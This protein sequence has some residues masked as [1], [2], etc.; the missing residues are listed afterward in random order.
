MV[1]Y[2]GGVAEAVAVEAALVLILGAGVR[3]PGEAC[4]DSVGNDPAGSLTLLGRRYR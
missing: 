2:V 4:A 3:Q 1:R